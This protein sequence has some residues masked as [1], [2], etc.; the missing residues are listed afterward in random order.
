MGHARRVHTF[1]PNNA[2]HTPFL[3]ETSSRMVPPF[4]PK[5]KKKTFYFNIRSIWM[6]FSINNFKREQDG[7]IK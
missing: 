1:K 5:I 6:N 2:V 7:K 4:N 3:V